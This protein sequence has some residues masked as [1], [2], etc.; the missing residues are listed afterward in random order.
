MQS[1]SLNL[2]LRFAAVDHRGKTQPLGGIRGHHE[3]SYLLL[4]GEKPT[5]YLLIF[6][7]HPLK[8]VTGGFT[9]GGQLGEPFR[10]TFPGGIDI[11][12]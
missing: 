2:S 9:F 6:L 5:R 11:N 7:P 8:Q 12:G 1:A 4:G 3:A 10:R